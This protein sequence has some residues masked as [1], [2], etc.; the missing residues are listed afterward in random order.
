MKQTAMHFFQLVAPQATQ[1]L[2]PEIWESSLPSRS[3][4]PPPA[5][6]NPHHPFLLT[7]PSPAATGVLAWSWWLPSGPWTHGQTYLGPAPREV[8]MA[9][10][11]SYF[12]PS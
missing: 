5:V 1:W 12:I 4:S 7:T 11:P 2:R 3:L 6:P 8:L 9:C 10:K